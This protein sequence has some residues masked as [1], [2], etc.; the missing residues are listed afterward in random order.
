MPVILA[1]FDNPETTEFQQR[2]FNFGEFKKLRWSLMRVTA[3][4]QSQQ[5]ILNVQLTF[6]KMATLQNQ[7]SSGN[8][9]SNASDN[10]VG[11][12]QILQN[13]TQTAQL[14]TDLSSISSATNVLQSSV[15]AITSAQTALTSVIN[16]AESAV[17][18]TNQAGANS[19]LAAQ[20]NTAINQLLGIAN[21]QLSDGTYIF[22][23]TATSKPPFVVSSTNATGQPASIVYQGNQQ[24]SQAIVGKSLTVSTSIPGSSVFQPNIGGT[25]TYSGSTG[26]AAGSG[27]DTA[28]GSA[29]LQVQHTLTSFAGNSGVA[30]GTSSADGDTILGPAGA[31]TLTINDTSGNGTSGTVTLNGGAT[32]AFTNSDTNLK[33]TGPSG[34]VVYLDT[35][36][37]TAGFKGTVDLTADGTLSVDGGATTTPINFSSS[38]AVTDGT[39]GAVTNVDSA[40]IRQTGNEQ[41]TYP[42]TSDLFQTLIALRDTINNTQG[43]SSTDRTAAIEQQISQLSNINT[44]MATPLGNQ[45]SQ[46]QF[47]SNLQTR[48][49][50]LQTN[51][52][53]NT[54]TI[55]STDMASAIVDLQQQQTLYQAGLQLAAGLN[56]LSLS[57]YINF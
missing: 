49:T 5:A 55:Q 24:S 35:S 37:I 11:M 57:N 44:A 40:N 30:A 16:T 9:I 52:K 25:T 53:A 18:P 1:S 36:A 29:T 39:T 45:S 51:L 48:N 50:T 56:Q 7:I 31:N 3:E 21:T 6:A 27:F 32:V 20:V 12:V 26:A 8:Q 19:T 54:S 34:E 28:T 15:S 33:V 41:L 38:Q 43:L 22:G 47:L 46:A 42:G 13:N 14:T 10:P 23:G 4:T 2:S 17:S